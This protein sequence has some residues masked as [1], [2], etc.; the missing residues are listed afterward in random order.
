M[1][2][3]GGRAGGPYLSPRRLLIPLRASPS[4]PAQYCLWLP[5]G[6]EV[7]RLAACRLELRVCFPM[8]R[9]RSVPEMSLSESS[10]IC[11]GR[12]PNEKSFPVGGKNC[13]R[14]KGDFA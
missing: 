7:P 5:G 13:K 10:H 3:G 8:N 9:R 6:A 1:G 2:A 4:P 12:S 11:I 14:R